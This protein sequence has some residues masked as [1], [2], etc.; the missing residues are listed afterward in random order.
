MRSRV[1]FHIPRLLCFLRKLV[2]KGGG[3]VD[4]SVLKKKEINFPKHN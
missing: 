3:V 2:S 4:G 1:L